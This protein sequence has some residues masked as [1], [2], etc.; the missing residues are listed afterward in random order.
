MRTNRTTVL[1]A[2]TLAVV[3]MLALVSCSAGG[4]PKLTRYEVDAD[5]QGVIEKVNNIYNTSI[6]SNDPNVF[7]AEYEAGFIQ[8]RLQE[9]QIIAARDNSWDSAYL[10]NPSHDFPKQIPPSPDEVA[11]AQRTLEANWDFTLQYIRT[12]RD[13]QVAKNLRR[14]M[15]RLIGIYDGA[16]KD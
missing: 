6:V 5:S 15:Y 2:V 8:G 10:T 4:G 3:S 9:D 12:S 11:M 7:K 16:A 1:V 14:L 13:A